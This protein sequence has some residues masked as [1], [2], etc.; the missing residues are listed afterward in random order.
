MNLK[1]IIPSVVLSLCA[2]FAFAS[3]SVI[4]ENGN[5]EVTRNKGDFEDYIKIYNKT[6]K[7]VTVNVKG[8]KKR[9]G[10]EVDLGSLRVAPFNNEEVECD[11]NGK[12]E[13]LAKIIFTASEGPI[14]EYS[15]DLSRNDLIFNVEKVGG[16]PSSSSSALS[17]DV[18]AKLL[19]YKTLFDQGVISQDEYTSLKAKLLGL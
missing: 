7:A 16:V 10:A 5:V 15:T 1:K 17:D 4:L 6:D 12:M 14:T 8:I 13:L 11:Y 3:P 9:G 18:T 2:F 19:K